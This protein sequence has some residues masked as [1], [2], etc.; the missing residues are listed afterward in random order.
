MGA[1]TTGRKLGIGLRLAARA[2]QR[3]GGSPRPPENPLRKARESFVSPGSIAAAVHSASHA[4][5]KAP[6]FA[7]GVGRGAKRFGQAL[8]GPMAHTGSVLSLEITGLFFALFA[9]FFGQSAY[10]MR[11]DYLRGP[12]NHHFLVYAGFTLIFAWFTFSNFY[13]ARQKEKRNRA[14]REQGAEHRAQ[15]AGDGKR[16]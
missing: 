5:A 9:I 16:H 6:T 11:R 12:E 14:R 1:E 8:W 13:K 7:Q 3:A 15:G 2:V 10:T 4:A